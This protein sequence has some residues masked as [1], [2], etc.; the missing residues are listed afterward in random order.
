[1]AAAA[2]AEASLRPES[3]LTLQRKQS[4]APEVGVSQKDLHLQLCVSRQTSESSAELW[5][6]GS[7]TPPPA[8]FPIQVQLAVWIYLIERIDSTQETFSC[9]FSLH[10]RWTDK[11]Y[12]LPDDEIISQ[13]GDDNVKHYSSHPK[14]GRKA[15]PFPEED[16]SMHGEKIPCGGSPRW[17]PEIKFFD[18]VQPP[19][20]IRVEYTANRLTGVVDCYYEVSRRMPPPPPP[21]VASK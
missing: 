4:W 19:E 8:C 21:A 14:I 10:Q 20:L 15:G 5:L 3:S 12:Q 6:P 9:R 2:E 13:G 11:Y 1:M 18:T 7:A 16:Y 17:T